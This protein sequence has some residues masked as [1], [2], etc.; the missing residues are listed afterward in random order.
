MKK[1]EAYHQSSY[2]DRLRASIDHLKA[3]IF[4]NEEKIKIVTREKKEYWFENYIKLRD[5]LANFKLKL[6]TIQER[7]K[8]KH[9]QR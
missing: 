1:S 9:Y 8:I 2:D 6:S 5:E 3:R 7:L 4:V